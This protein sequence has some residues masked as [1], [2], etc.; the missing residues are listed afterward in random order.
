ML[1]SQTPIYNRKDV[2]QNIIIAKNLS[3]HN[4]SDSNW[5]TNSLLNEFENNRKVCSKLHTTTESGPN[6]WQVKFVRNLFFRYFYF[7][8]VD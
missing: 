6:S 4:W 7:C 1:L 8:V 2:L 3:N 5:S